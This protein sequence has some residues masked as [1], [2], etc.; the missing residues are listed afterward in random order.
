[1]DKNLKNSLLFGAAVGGLFAL[2]RNAGEKQK[3]TPL[4]LKGI[5]DLSDIFVKVGDIVSENLSLAPVYT[6][7]KEL[8]PKNNTSR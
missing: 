8:E 7:V 6:Q 1:M 3:L 5:N 4:Q 2:L